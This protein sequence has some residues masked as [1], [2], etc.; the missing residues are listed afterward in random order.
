MAP[1]TIKFTTYNVKGLNMANKRRN[2]FNEFK[3]LGPDVIFLQETH[4]SHQ[5]R[6]RL[7]SSEYPIW[8]QG[9]TISS[10]T[11][12]VAIRFAKKIRFVLEDRIVDPEGRY[13]LLKGRLNE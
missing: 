13:L 5:S 12:G 3:L 6:L 1:N 9:D 7:F 10:R 2:I 4:I 11:R 8:Y